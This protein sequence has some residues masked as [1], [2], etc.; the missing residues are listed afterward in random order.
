MCRGD[1]PRGGAC[2]CVRCTDQSTADPIAKRRT[3]RFNSPKPAT[4]IFAGD[5]QHREQPPA[6]ATETQPIRRQQIYP[7]SF[8]SAKVDAAIL[9]FQQRA[10]R[11]TYSGGAF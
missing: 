5:G 11:R 2:N 10:D 7:P 3:I 6:R 8:S 4:S 1:Q 9:R